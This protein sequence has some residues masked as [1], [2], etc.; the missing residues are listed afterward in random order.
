MN[1]VA[2]AAN[3]RLQGIASLQQGERAK[4]KGQLLHAAELF[5]FGDRAWKRR[6][7]STSQRW[8]GRT[9]TRERYAPPSGR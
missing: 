6:P 1:Y 4:A 5:R 2:T 8:K 3:L 9:A 7:F